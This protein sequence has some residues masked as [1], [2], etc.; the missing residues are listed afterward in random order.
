MGKWHCRYTDP[1]LHPNPLKGLGG[2]RIADEMAKRNAWLVG[3]L[4]LPPWDYGLTPT[5]E[6][7][8]KIM[9]LIYRECSNARDKGLN[10]LCFSGFHPAEVDKLIDRYSFKPL[11]VLELAY[12]VLGLIKEKC[13][14]GELDGIGEVGHQHYKTFPDRVLISHYIMEKALEIAL[15][16][17]CPIQLHLENN[18]H[19]TVEIVDDTV[20]RLGGHPSRRIVFHHSK[21]SMAEKA[22]GRGYSATVPGSNRRLLEHVFSKL[23][24][25]Y[26]VE[27][28]YVDGPQKYARNHPWTIIETVNNMIEEGIVSEE[29]VCKINEDLPSK[30]FN[31]TP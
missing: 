7:Y 2:S 29:Y 4:S 5:L 3:F 15:D 6:N 12:K 1:H 9:N 28:D 16:E 18:E 25:V 22:F 19:S 14:R 30:A 11:E 13:R 8:E 17:D 21:P 23:D 20:K 27:S 26:M 10:V 31:V 24:P